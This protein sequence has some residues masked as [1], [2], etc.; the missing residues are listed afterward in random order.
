MMWLTF[1]LNRM[2]IRFDPLLEVKR[3][4][5][6]LGMAMVIR[7]NKLNIGVSRANMHHSDLEPP[8]SA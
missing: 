6:G 4:W 8:Y 3:P 7:Q 5:H 2:L 1:W